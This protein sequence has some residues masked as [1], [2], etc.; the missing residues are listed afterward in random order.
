[1]THLIGSQGYSQKEKIYD[2]HYPLAQIIIDQHIKP[3]QIEFRALLDQHRTFIILIPW[4]VPRVK[5]DYNLCRLAGL[6]SFSAW[7]CMLVI[8]DR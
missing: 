1:M 4:S 2:L 6:R 7:T 8:D 3:L 5:R